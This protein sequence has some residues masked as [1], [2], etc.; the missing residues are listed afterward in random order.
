MDS[1]IRLDNNYSTME[2]E[3]DEE[4]D[5]WAVVIDD[6]TDTGW[7]GIYVYIYNGIIFPALNPAKIF[8]FNSR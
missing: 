3:K 2:S 8:Q 5:P 4:D 7:P 6:G 1:K